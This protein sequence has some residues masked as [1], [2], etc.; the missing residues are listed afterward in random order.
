MMAELYA[1]AP[2]VPASPELLMQLHALVGKT[3]P[4]VAVAAPVAA[5]SSDTISDDEFEALLDQ[6]QGKPVAA[7]VVATPPPRVVK[8][9]PAAAPAPAPAPV[10]K[11][12]V[13]TTRVDR[14]SV[15]EGKGGSGRVTLGGRRLLKKK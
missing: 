11:A 14:K 5:G 13:E 7:P 15:V 12:E 6:L 9:S 8:P 3:A 2:L 10:A 1:N 4:V